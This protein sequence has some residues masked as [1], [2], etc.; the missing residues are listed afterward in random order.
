M[1]STKLKLHSNEKIIVLP[2]RK[3]PKGYK[4]AITNYG[5]VI[6]FTEEPETGRFLKP[7]SVSGY[8]AIAVRDKGDN[9]TFLIH[10]LVAT[11]FL[12]QPDKTYKYVLHLNNK[13]DDNHYQ[14]LKWATFEQQ[15]K[16]IVKNRRATEIGNYKLTAERVVLIKKQIASGKTRL[17]MIAK[18]F[19]VTDMQIHRIKTGENWGY[20]K[21]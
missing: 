20:V 3:T 7:S 9:K 2:I 18:R 21:I 19:G 12:R 13:K 16:H 17:K 11:H 5:R 8:P 10:R 1:T 4:Y 15:I 6:S 14:N